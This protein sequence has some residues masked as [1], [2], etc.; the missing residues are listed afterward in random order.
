[1][2]GKF[3][4]VFDTAARDKFLGA[5]FSMLKADEQNCIWIF[6]KEEAER[7]C[8]DYCAAGFEYVLSDTLTF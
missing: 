3:I 4:Y 2:E 7:L 5:G 8:F 6:S 1:M